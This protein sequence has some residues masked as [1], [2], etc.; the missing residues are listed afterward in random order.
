[1]LDDYNDDIITSEAIWTFEDVEKELLRAYPNGNAISE[2]IHTIGGGAW[3]VDFY[4]NG[5]DLK[6]F[7]QLIINVTLINKMNETTN[8]VQA[9][10]SF[11]FKNK[12]RRKH[13]FGKIPLTSFEDGQTEED[14]SLDN[15][16][17]K[18]CGSTHPISITITI[19][20]YPD[21]YEY[22][23]EQILASVKANKS[24]IQSSNSLENISSATPRYNYLPGDQFDDDDFKKVKVN[25]LYNRNIIF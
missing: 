6:T 19:N 1:M 2:E 3:R 9:E 12:K 18:E 17:L 22:P 25:Y 11:S 14:S 7:G 23:T 21:D 4:P 16:I 5:K 15:S 13:Y 24:M 10:C 8:P 20:Q